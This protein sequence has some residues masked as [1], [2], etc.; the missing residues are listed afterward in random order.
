M[1]HPIKRY[2]PNEDIKYNMKKTT[3]SSD[4][5]AAEKTSQP[6]QEYLTS[7]MSSLALSEQNIKTE[8]GQNDM[9]QA[10]EI[11]Q[12][13]G[14]EGADGKDKFGTNLFTSEG[15]QA[16][17]KD[18]DQIFDNADDI[19]SDEA[20]QVHTPPNSN[21]SVGGNEDSKKN[22]GSGNPNMPIRPE[23]LS[24]M[25]PTPPSLEHHPNSSPCGAGLCDAPMNDL[26]KQEIYPNLGSPANEPVDDWSY[27]FTPPKHFKFVGSTKYAPLTNLPSQT[28]PPIHLPTNAFYNP[29]WKNKNSKRN[30]NNNLQRE[31]KLPIR[32]VTTTTTTVA[33]A[34]ATPTAP[35][36]QQQLHQNFNHSFPTTPRP[37]SAVSIPGCNSNSM[38]MGGIPQFQNTNNMLRPGM[39]PISPANS[40]PPY[41]VGSPMHY[42]RTPLPP[43]P[44][45]DL[46]VASPA[47]STCSMKQF[48]SNEPETPSAYQRAPEA[49]ALLVNVLLCD[50]A[51][52]IFRDH[53]FDSCTLCV[54]N[55]GI[56]CVGNI[57]GADSGVY[58]ALPGNN[59]N[60]YQSQNSYTGGSAFGM[61]SPA[62]YPNQ[63]GYLDEDPINCRCG[64]SAV[65]NR[66]LS[67]RSGLF[68]EDEMEITG[69]A[70]DPGN[71]KKNSLMSYIL[72]GGSSSKIKLENS[73]QCDN[74]QQQI[75]DLIREQL[76]V[77]QSS[78]NSIQRILREFVSKNT[79]ESSRNKTVH[80][81]E[82]IDAHDVINLVLE[83]SR[84]AYEMSMCKMELDNYRPIKANISVHKWPYVKA[85]GPRSNQDIIRIM[86]SMQPL[87]Q[88]AFHKKSTTR[89]W[90]APYTVQGPLTWRQFHRMAAK[91]TTGQCEPQPIPTV[92]VGHEKD[93]LSVAPYAI[94][95]WDKLLLEP[96]SY[97]RDVVYCVVAPDNDDVIKMVKMYFKELST[98]YEMCKLGKHTPIKGWDGILRVN[99]S[100]KQNSDQ[101]DEWF[102]MLGDSKTS[103]M[104]KLYAHAFQNHLVPYLAKIPLDK[105]L[106]D[107][108][109]SSN[110]NF[111]NNLNR[112]RLLPSPMPP[113]S[114]PDPLQQSSSGGGEKP[115]LTP[116]IETGKYFSFI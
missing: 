74:V 8:S 30:I 6:F 62:G 92:I 51:L 95:Y 80:L 19:S 79:A 104:L 17:Y 103:E 72:S 7:T 97:S 99:K 40:V 77:V 112:D 11:K 35:T 10:H 98:T 49:N 32:Q 90:D 82:Y 41:S 9:L 60:N 22:I 31:E 44:P 106:L 46:A 85:G 2:K 27:V 21:K 28:L 55:A 64:F 39:S 66:R 52:N 50:T 75:V 42:R 93:W 114:T 47:N 111:N 107:P 84:L 86:K 34:V 23:E 70:E 57:R 18:L 25:F 15:L 56:K 54:C 100:M 69:M 48:N 53:N 16:S 87:L 102:S 73:E 88:D 43:P 4:L 68:Y 33:T 37:S 108:P 58:L 110:I 38:N 105:S 113:P 45:Y 12:E 96:Y 83:Q 3:Y 78:S 101:I 59:F 29:S 67:H 76:V 65:V 109:D 61:D 13:P 20:L 115:M 24:K 26:I 14:A 71:Y 1:N 116:K 81:L 63:N 94:H 36:Q 89:L 91:G 5:Y